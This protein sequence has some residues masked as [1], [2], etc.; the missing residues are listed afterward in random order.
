MGGTVRA[1]WLRVAA[2]CVVSAIGVAPLGAATLPSGFSETVLASGLARPTAMALAPDGRVF[3]CL[4]DG[5][6]RVIENGTLLPTPFLSLTVSST[7]ERGLLGVAVDPNFETNGFVYVYYTATPT[8]H[9]RVSRFTANGN[10]AIASSEVVLLELETLSSATNH[11]GGAL[12]FGAD[13]KLYVAVGD[14]ANGNNSQT[15]ANRLGKVL[16]INADGSIPTDNPF[17]A[18]AAGA[19]RAI[20][21]LGLRNPFTFAVQ[22]QS[23]RILIND[24]GQNT[25]E[26]VNDGIA[27]ANYGWPTTEGPTTNPS[28]V[29]PLYA[30]QHSSGTPTGCAISGGAFY[31]P[32]VQQ[33]PPEFFGAY[34]FADYCGGWI[35]WLDPSA[36]P[37]V[38][39]A[40]ASGIASPV[41][42]RVSEDGALY[43]LAR[44]SGSTTG[45][46]SRIAYTGSQAPAITEQPS[47]VI[48]SVGQPATFTV[49]ASGSAPLSYQWQ[50]NGADI[51]GAT[52]A[53]YTLQ[54]TALADS[55]STFRCIVSNSTGSATSNAATLTV[56]P[57]VTPV[58]TILSPA[59][60]TLYAGGSVISY[61][62]SA[63]DAEDG[64]LSAAA[65]TWQVDFH[66]DA[67]THPFVPPTNGV[68]GGS[69]VVPT[70]GET[71]ANVWY[72]IVLTVRDSAGQTATTFRDVLPR[73]VRVTL[74]SSPTGM[75]LTLDGVPV[76]AP[77]AFTGVVGIERVISAPA[78]QTLGRRT[79]DFVS[80]SDGG[81][82]THTIST[83]ATDTTLT[84][85]YR[86]R[87]GR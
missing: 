50:R 27:G 34:F 48:V 46:L 73:T 63:S 41:D 85:V 53:S 55:G 8:V 10:V 19:N 32:L 35:R 66:H 17:Y 57:N 59:V 31:H 26:E 77:F 28:F 24:V 84:A 80:W 16:R 38:S 72:R 54:S 3:V 13:G 18:T 42:L 79:Y 2:V 45:V 71:S 67:H 58:P 60:G 78:A 5:Q 21:V 25:W 44:G 47:S 51:A 39:T 30:Y 56:V 1:S 36:Y 15:L 86:K 9:N 37:L 23:G 40:F 64:G 7:G 83:P 70:N 52:V 81:S 87:K 11:N 75:G 76:T 49:G 65:F 82:R 74:A 43:Y 61:S 33:F 62:G 12:H 29:S 4:Q 22:A 20:W 14:D 68:T 6:L 69:F